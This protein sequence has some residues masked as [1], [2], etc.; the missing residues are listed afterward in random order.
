MVFWVFLVLP[1]TRI[2]FLSK[3]E[4]MWSNEI[5]DGVV[6]ILSEMER[7]TIHSTEQIEEIKDS[8]VIY[9]MD[10]FDLDYFL[11]GRLQDVRSDI[12][13][14]ADVTD[15]L[16]G[17]Y[18]KVAIAVM[19][20]ELRIYQRGKKRPRFKRLIGSGEAAWMWEGR[21]EAEK[22]AYRNLMR[23]IENYLKRFFAL[24]GKIIEKKNRLVKIN[25]GEK[26]GVKERMVFVA[27]GKKGHG[28]F[29]IKK[30]EESA[31]LGYI[32]K[33]VSRIKKGYKI[34]ECPNGVKFLYLGLGYLGSFLIMDDSSRSSQGGFVGLRIGR[35]YQ[36]S[37]TVLLGF[38]PIFY[39]SLSFGFSPLIYIGEDISFGPRIGSRFFF[40][41]QSWEANDGGDIL[42]DTSGTATGTGVAGGIG[43]VFRFDYQLFHVFAL[44][45]KQVS[46]TITDWI[47]SKKIDDETQ[48]ERVPERYLKIERLKLGDY[49]FRIGIGLNFEIY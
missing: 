43:G 26:N 8:S 13:L 39:T 25:L 49:L 45:E 33:G 35:K 21:E 47:F 4:D 34:R 19:D 1:E 2:G 20:Y 48:S 38:N 6:R 3:T 42:G 22:E 36:F 9:I 28:F 5:K 18:K 10:K 15:T 40:V 41:S 24:R 14:Y 31:S 32:F 7:F 23:E 37:S 11:V 12:K 46:T 16:Y 30:V 29:K 44:F 27:R 17:G